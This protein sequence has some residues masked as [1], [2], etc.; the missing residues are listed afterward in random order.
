[1]YICVFQIIFCWL[2]FLLIKIYASEILCLPFGDSKVPWHP[3]NQLCFEPVS[4]FWLAVELTVFWLKDGSDAAQIYIN[5][6]KSKRQAI[7]YFTNTVQVKKVHKTTE[8]FLWY[9]LTEINVFSGNC[10]AIECNALS[11]KVYLR[12]LK[13]SWYSYDN[14]H[15][16]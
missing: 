14:N 9:P 13:P 12:I 4:F 3:W 6:C 5:S 1:M 16:P 15:H 7:K 11:G 2:F 8:Y 10:F